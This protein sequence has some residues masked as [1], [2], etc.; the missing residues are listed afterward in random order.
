[1]TK[2]MFICHGNICRSP[3]AEFVMKDMVKRRGLSGKFL[4]AS[5]ATSGEE[6]GNPVFPPIQDLMR[7]RGI[8][9]KDRSAVRLQPGDYAK[10]D[11]FVAMDEN[12]L[13]NIRRI[14]P[15]DPREKVYKLL[16]FCGEDGDIA[17]PWYYGNFEAVYEQIAR[18]C[19]AL[20]E[21][22]LLQR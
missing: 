6:I 11:L 15:D 3:L 22:C 5:S 1:M 9:F 21:R 19:S 14:F 4:I 8:P 18:G 7:R 16:S 13:R 10:Y 17:D 20:L 2:I 12:N